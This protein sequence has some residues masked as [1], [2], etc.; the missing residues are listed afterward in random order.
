MQIVRTVVWVALLGPALCA[1]AVLVLRRR[2]RW[3]AAHG[4]QC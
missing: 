4:W 2:H 3:G 1:V